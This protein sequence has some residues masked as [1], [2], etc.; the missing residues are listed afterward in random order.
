MAHKNVFKKDLFYDFVTKRNYKKIASV[1]K[2]SLNKLYIQATYK[3]TNLKLWKTL[4]YRD[5]HSNLYWMIPLV[6]YL[7]SYDEAS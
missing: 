5:I 2:S 7:R 3:M 1:R 6:F 4:G